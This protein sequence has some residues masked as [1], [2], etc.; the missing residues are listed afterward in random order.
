MSTEP[1]N[2]LLQAADEMLRRLKAETEWLPKDYP[3][4]A[5]VQR[6]EKLIEWHYIVEGASK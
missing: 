5:L 6:A 3:P 1:T 2:K 4:A